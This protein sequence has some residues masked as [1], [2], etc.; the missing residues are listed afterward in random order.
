MN[1]SWKELE[2]KAGTRYS[3]RDVWK[4]ASSGQADAML[5][6][7]LKPHETQVFV[8]TPTAGK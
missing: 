2:L 5:S 4:H 3:V 6:A 8:L 1:A 7:D